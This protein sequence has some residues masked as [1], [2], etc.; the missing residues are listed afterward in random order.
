MSTSII[1]DQHR[2]CTDLALGKPVE[3]GKYDC[4]NLT[5]TE[6]IPVTKFSEPTKQTQTGTIAPRSITTTTIRSG[7]A[8]ITTIFLPLLFLAFSTVV[9]LDS[10]QK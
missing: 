9:F 4:N 5:V 7:G 6:N 1:I 3:S 10:W 8:D 2:Y